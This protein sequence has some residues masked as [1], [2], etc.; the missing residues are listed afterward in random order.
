MALADKVDTG[1][2]NAIDPNLKPFLGHG[3]KLLL[4]HGWND[5][6]IAPRNSVNYY[7]SVVAKL[8][9]AAKTADSLRLFM[10]PGM[11]HCSG[12]DG[13]EHVRHGE[14]ARVSGWREGRRP[15]RSPPRT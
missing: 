14:R 1:L 8:G 10:V 6:L 7:K 11:A 5:Q 13:T 9:G 12:G 4:Y 15:T 2:L 3:G